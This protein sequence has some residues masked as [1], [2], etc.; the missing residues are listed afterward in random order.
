MTHLF[1]TSPFIQIMYESLKKYKDHLN[2]FNHKLKDKLK[3]N[4]NKNE[5][6]KK[7][8]NK[9]HLHKNLSS[10]Y[11]CILEHIIS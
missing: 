2:T 10:H 1:L 6:T 7:S 3:R 11:L 9:T 5:L 4:S 8:S